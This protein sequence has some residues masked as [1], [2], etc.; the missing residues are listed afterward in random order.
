LFKDASIYIVKQAKGNLPPDK[1]IVK[2]PLKCR[3]EHSAK[4]CSK[5]R[6]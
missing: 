3:D 2:V 5:M 4:L 1:N 6:W